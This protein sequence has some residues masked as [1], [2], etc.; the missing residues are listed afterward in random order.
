MKE[1]KNKKKN[2]KMVSLKNEERTFIET[3][4]VFWS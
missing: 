3:D 4:E 1:A 2:K